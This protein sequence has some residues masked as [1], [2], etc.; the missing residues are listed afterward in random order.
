[1]NILLKEFKELLK[2]LETCCLQH[3]KDFNLDNVVE[4]LHWEQSVPDEEPGGAIARMSDGKFMALE[5]S[6]DYSGH[7]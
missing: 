1:M 6:Q 3:P 7:G 2:F 5:E 4:V